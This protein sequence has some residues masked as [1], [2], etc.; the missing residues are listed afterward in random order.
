LWVE[1]QKPFVSIPPPD[2]NPNPTRA[3]LILGLF[4]AL[5]FWFIASSIKTFR[6]SDR[7]VTVKGL[8]E[9]EVAAD[10]VIWPLVFNVTDND[11]S[12]LQTKIQ[13]GRSNIKSFLLSMGFAESE[14]SISSPKI[15]DHK[16]QGDTNE[17]VLQNSRYSA[18]AAVLLRSNKVS[19]AKK[20]MEQS[21]K[22]VRQGVALS[23]NNYENKVEF[24]FTGLNQ[25][26]ASMIEEATLDA[27]RSADKFAKDSRSR[28]GAIRR[29]TQGYFE[30]NDRDFCSPDRKIVRVVTTVEYF[31]K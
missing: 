31:L 10:L 18:E 4:I 15:T 25:L 19:E 13:S 29:A 8:A 6:T 5:G 16:A 7:S 1:N 28:V 21:D 23:G 30:I 26:K 2:M 22:L 3:A 12:A 20:A 11:L 27:R 9:K 17:K 14:L 24:L